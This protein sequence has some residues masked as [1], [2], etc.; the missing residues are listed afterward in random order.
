MTMVR[1]P[2]C[3]RPVEP[4]LLRRQWLVPKH[5]NSRKKLCAGT[6]ARAARAMRRAR[7]DVIM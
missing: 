3:T 1:C 4:M 2:Y 7:R 5:D 6:G